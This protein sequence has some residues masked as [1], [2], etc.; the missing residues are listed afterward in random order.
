MKL[1]SIIAVLMT[2][3]V[4]A[5]L[6]VSVPLAVSASTDTRVPTSDESNTGGFTTSPLWSKVD[7]TTPNDSD[8]IVGVNN[9]GGHCTFGF[10]T[11]SVPGGS[12]ISSVTVFYRAQDAAKGANNIRASLKV[13][14]TYYDT[15]ATSN[16]PGSS[17]TTYSYA[18]ATNPKT[19]IA[20]TV[21]DVNGIGAN[22]LQAFGV[23]STD[24][25]PDIQVSMVYMV[26]NYTSSNPIPT[27]T[28]ISPSSKTVGDAQF[29]MTVSGTNFISSSVVQFAG[30]NR[31]TTFVS[32]T[33]LTATILASDLMTAGQFNITVFNPT[34]GGGTSNA[35]IFTVIYSPTTVTI[36]KYDARG[37][38]I[39][40]V[41]KN[42]Q[43][44]ETN[45]P[46]QG[47]DLAR[48]YHQGPTFNDSSYNALWD[49]GET[50]NIDTRDYGRAK[51]TDVK[52]LCNLVGGATAGDTIKITATDNFAKWFDYED[53]Y[54]PEAAQGKLVVCWYNED[55][56]GYV[57]GYSTGM[58]L[59]FFTETLNPDGKH[60]FGDWDMY[61][62]LPMSRWH[63]Y[64]DGNFWPSSSGLSVQNVAKIEIFQ[65][66][67][68]S[69]DATGNAK[70][71]FAAGE[72]VY[73]KG[74]GLS[75]STGYKLWIQD[76]PV[77]PNA[78][79][80]F[81][82]P[83]GNYV[84]NGA[85]D[86]SGS[87]EAVTTNGSGDF[88]P[89]AIWSIPTS[90]TA[91]QYDIVADNQASGTI[92]TYGAYDAIDN[93]GW[94]GFS[95]TTGPSAPVAAF[96]ADVTSGMAPLMVH[97]T[98]TST[99]SPTSW[100]WDIDNNGN[101]DYTTQNPTHTYNSV[102]TYSVKLTATNAGG[103]DDETKLDYIVVAALPAPVANF[104]ADTT[105][106]MAPL[107]VHFTDTSTGS[108]TSWAWDI[109]NDG[110]TD[111]STQNPI[112]TY[113]SAGTY[114]V[115]L[116]A[117]NAGG[118]DDEIKTNYISVLVTITVTRVPISDESN[119]GGFT[120]SPLWSKV[121][122]T[123]PNDSDY[124]IGVSNS[125]GHCTFGFSAFS[126]PGGST[127][128]SV[129]VFYRAADAKS[130]A[131]NIRASLKVDGIYYDT[132][133]TSNDPGSGFVTYSYSFTTNPKTGVAWTVDDINGIGAN[134]LQAFGVASTDF[135]PDI[136]V[137]MVYLSVSYY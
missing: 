134:A 56:G 31:A 32:S 116:M 70:D 35:Q 54:F 89:T 115:K 43:W 36:T 1:K 95:V 53:V 137:S 87:P 111:Y 101:I 58:R 128:S 93:P 38:V 108:P 17:F 130:G 55:F 136:Q 76:E 127:I 50:V 69:C 64:Y 129:T 83:A 41:A 59:I 33:Q 98:D 16:N 63:F 118:S 48:R 123:T 110:D 25:N 88:G 131:N 106:G 78:R 75:A 66:K 84:L 37:G 26:V 47:T 82:R 81:E 15:T 97:F 24:F 57:P 9:G 125:G 65:P 27:T 51:G 91:K 10:S 74:V 135:N 45:L 23:A 28:S 46:V 3:L 72:T 13:G 104:Y 68:I 40:Q 99:G 73:V 19:G 94:Q 114:S 119:T 71:S 30:S 14:G 22:P 113:N 102:G 42:Y 6:F 18:F 7:E 11:F 117:T 120:T 100:A 121:D 44:L 124:I 126:V 85:N 60:V 132:I 96:T 4:I 109:D 61:N 103:S 20:W 62:T 2:T 8:Y 52:D 5:T 79:D 39:D 49:P 107:T 77:T 12:G 112:H 34:P 29:T 80:A 133:A 92:G 105:S 90:A 122:E 21:D 86:P 67:L